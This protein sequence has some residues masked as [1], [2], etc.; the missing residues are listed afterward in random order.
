MRL[1]EDSSAEKLR[2]GFYTPAPIVKAC[3]ER[4]WTLLPDK[5]RLR[6][7]EPSAGDGAFI[8]YFP[9]SS[10]R[11]HAEIQAV[12]LLD[13][14]AEKC[15]G[16]LRT[17][18]IKGKVVV[19]SFFRWVVTSPGS[20]DAVVGNPPFVRYQFIP[21][22]DRALAEHLVSTHGQTLDGVSN[23]WIP[24]TLLSLQLLKTGGAFAFVIPG[25]FLCTKSG[26]LIRSELIRHFANLRVDFYPRGSFPRI[27]QDVTI[28]SGQRDIAVKQVRDVVFHDH[29]HG[30]PRE[31]THSIADTGESWTR[32]LLT[33]QEW[34]AYSS[35]L[36]HS[37]VSRLGD[38]ATISVS[39]VTGANPFFTVDEETKCEY[40]LD[41][42]SRPLLA[43]T[44]DSPGIVFS[45]RD[46]TLAVK[47][48][49]VGWILDFAPNRPDPK[50]FKMPSRYLTMGEAQDLPKRYKC[51]I[52]EPWYVVP[53]FQFGDL[54]LSK[55][56]H[57][58]HRLIL[59]SASV[60]TT[61][62][63]YRGTM[64]PGKKRLLRHVVA[65]FHN[66]LTLLSTELEGRT[67]GG[68]VLEL[69][70][71]EVARVV[72]PVEKMSDHLSTLDAVCRKAGGQQDTDDRLLNATDEILSNV[73][74]DYHEV[75]PHLRSAHERLRERRFAG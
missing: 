48:G 59:N 36:T 53:N 45:K 6:I 67:Y 9:K 1:K 28:V 66:S 22:S 70:P 27:L 68:G 8:R 40:E 19:D 20:F 60:F 43:R 38:L 3:Y 12:E 47:R 32:Y 58:F 16:E 63:V 7:L 17:A 54:M 14:E 2:G 37:S 18:G 41:R 73:R 65:G 11:R 25:E 74:P 29:G 39:I 44:V 34:E 31:W 62:T 42:W 50:S 69:V 52:R 4:L 61:D 64:K 72:V 51:R 35:S 26:K 33:N 23:L 75:L 10:R 46:H 13:T 56:A 15:R 24:I 30:Q 5:S 21:K 55:R 49:R 71:S 57:R